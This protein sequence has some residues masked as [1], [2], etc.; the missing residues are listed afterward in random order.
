M[1]VVLSFQ[2]YSNR[3]LEILGLDNTFPYLY[4]TDR[5]IGEDINPDAIINLDNAD[6]TLNDIVSVL[7]VTYSSEA[8]IDDGA[9]QDLG[10]EESE[11]G[12]RIT[13]DDFGTILMLAN[14]V[15]TAIEDEDDYYHAT[16]NRDALQSFF[17]DTDWDNNT[18]YVNRWSDEDES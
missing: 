12:F 4:F 17:V 8:V 11:Y 5:Q 9:L 14:E 7:G 16:K 15:L 6:Q 2:A 13:K 10:G 1:G 18:V 3:E